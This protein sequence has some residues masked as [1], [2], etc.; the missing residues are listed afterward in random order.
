MWAILNMS[1]PTGGLEYDRRPRGSYRLHNHFS[2]YRYGGAVV[3]EDIKKILLIVG[4]VSMSL[5]VFLE[6]F[7]FA[8]GC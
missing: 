1:V 8:K 2:T 6:I 4:V 5:Y 7:C 3:M